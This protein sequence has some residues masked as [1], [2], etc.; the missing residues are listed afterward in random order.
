MAPGND[1]LLSTPTHGAP[2]A[3]G[4]IRE[5]TEVAIGSDEN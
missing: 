2:E 1:K 4:A 5:W 3:S